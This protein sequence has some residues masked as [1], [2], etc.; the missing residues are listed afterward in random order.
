MN[1]KWFL[2]DHY[3]TRFACDSIEGR[4]GS[5]FRAHPPRYGGATNFCAALT[6]AARESDQ[7]QS[8]MRE[9]DKPCLFLS[10]IAAAI[11]AIIR[12]SFLSSKRPAS[13]Q[14]SAARL[15]A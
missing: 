14:L 1:C 2:K 3:P 9:P 15:L 12:V 13:D 10:L 5:K 6:S 7:G 8:D 4:V 11:P